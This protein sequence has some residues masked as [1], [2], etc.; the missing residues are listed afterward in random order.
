VRMG[1]CQCCLL[2]CCVLLCCVMFVHL[3][4]LEHF[5]FR[6]ILQGVPPK[7]V[8][9]GVACSV[10]GVESRGSILFGANFSVARFTFP[11][12]HLNDTLP[13]GALASIADILSIG[14]YTSMAN[15]LC[16]G[17]GES[18]GGVV[19]GAGADGQDTADA[20]SKSSL[21]PSP[22][23]T[24]EGVLLSVRLYPFRMNVSARLLVPWQVCPSLMRNSL[25]FAL[26]ASLTAP[27]LVP[28]VEH[29]AAG[30]MHIR[31]LGGDEDSP[32]P[33]AV[34]DAVMD[35]TNLIT[36]RCTGLQ[37][38]RYLRLASNVSDASVDYRSI[39]AAAKG[40]KLAKQI[41]IPQSSDSGTSGS[42]GNGGAGAG[43]GGGGGGGETPTT[44]S[45]ARARGKQSA[46]TPTPSSS[47]PS[48]P[49]LPSSG[50][51]SNEEKTDV[52]LTMTDGRRFSIR[53]IPQKIGKKTRETDAEYRG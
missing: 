14:N 51:G 39:N 49:Q 41:Q 11:S 12:T 40:K 35:A 7:L 15:P 26:R 43:G 4:L 3:L 23:L 38:S 45:A 42:S 1:V 53:D 19:A 21:H 48:T 33:A 37:F 34:C 25:T 17:S 18:E 13:R 6:V 29:G 24:V 46:G 32:F 30:S 44:W 2:V 5:V 36:T 10:E 8:A 47:S 9:G 50:T 52:T 16:S 20:H 28:D 31:V 22:L 27:G